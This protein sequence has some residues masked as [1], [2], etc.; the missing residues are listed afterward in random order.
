[1]SAVNRATD[2]FE[3]AIPFVAV[4]AIALVGYFWFVQPRI[5]E[6][7]RNRT[8]IANLEGRVRT[9]QDTVNRGKGVVTPD[10]AAALK[11]FDE[12]VSKDDTVSEIVEMLARTAQ[13]SAPDGRVLG[14]RIETGQPVTWQ[15]G[16]RPAT[17]AAGGDTDVPDSP[18]PRFGLFPVALKYTPV[19]VSFESSYGAIARFVW[20]LRDLPTTI[21]IRSMA[22]Q[23]GLPLMKASIRI[24]VYQRGDTV[25]SPAVPLPGPGGPASGPAAPRVAR[26]SLAEGW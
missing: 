10:E 21:E 5:A 6:V 20:Q 3:R 22:L 1:M 4:A 19:T 13:A 25:V 17:V 24:F 14:L 9:L 12:R 8:E 15:P 26:L 2:T 11:L 18:D 16:Q 7:L 23:R